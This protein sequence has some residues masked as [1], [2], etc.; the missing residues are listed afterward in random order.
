[1][2]LHFGDCTLDRRTR[3]LFRS[4]Q[5]IHVG[6][7]LLQLLEL[8]LDSQPRALTKDEIHKSVWPDTFVSDAT[9]TSLIADLRSAIGD[10]ARAPHLVRTVHGYGYAFAAS[11]SATGAPQPLSES[12]C[13]RIIYGD[14]EVSLASGDNVLGRSREAAI[15]VD[16]VGASRQHAKITISKS[17]AVLQDLASK[18]GT[19]LNGALV[20]QPTPLVDGARVGIGSTILVFRLFDIPGTTQTLVDDS[21]QRK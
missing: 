9:L 20:R 2:R 13:Y 1:M 12:R 7:K 10:D 6:P 3:E 8:L 17:G 5:V 16:D 4:G 21:G 11:V 18:N 19:S 14:R 15:F